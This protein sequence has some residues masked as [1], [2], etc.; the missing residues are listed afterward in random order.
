VVN[1][2]GKPAAEVQC[3]K[4]QQFYHQGEPVTERY[5]KM[6]KSLKNAVSPDEICQR[7]GA[8]TLRLY[9]MYLGPLEA[10][11]PW[12]T[13]DIIGV[14]RFL[15][16]LWRNFIDEQSGDLRV[17]DEPAS[18]EQLGLLHR[19][20]N[21]VGDDMERLSFNTAIAAMIEMNNELVQ[22][23]ALPRAVAEPVLKMIAPFAP[24]LAEELWSRLGHDDLI[25]HADWPRVDDRYLVRATVEIPVQI[26]GKVRSRIE[27]PSDASEEDMKAA[28]LADDR[29]AQ[30]IEDKTIRK[31]ITVPGKMVNIVAN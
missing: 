31:V 12:N 9:E 15:Q 20:L 26:L 11:K 22:W 30:L 27:I 1:Q 24:H 2:D 10:S 23:E 16:R 8:D 21:R 19:T 18:D 28:A 14:H 25:V 17:I 6:G 13:Q 29:I 3:E 7:F 5:G 4:G